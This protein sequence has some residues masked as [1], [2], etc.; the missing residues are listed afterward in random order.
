MTRGAM[1]D[2]IPGRSRQ[3][4]HH[5]PAA[6]LLTAGLLLAPPAAEA[7]R[8]CADPQEQSVFEVAALKS[9]LMVVGIACKVEDRY[10]AFVERFRPQL[11]E[12]DRALGQYFNRARGRAGQRASDAYITNLAQ[13]RSNAGQQL[14]SD[15]CP[16]NTGLFAEVMA[17]PRDGDLAAY[18]AGKDLV[19]TTLGACEEPPAA[20]APA[21]RAASSSSSRARA[22]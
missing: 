11:I 8:R 5:R 21:R 15:F 7:A 14:G 12:N 3:T 10:N 19:P 13:G 20:A 4:R 22:R 9:E 2:R 16:R 18:A 1:S 6:A 17:L